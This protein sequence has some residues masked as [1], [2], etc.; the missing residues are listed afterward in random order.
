MGEEGGGGC[1]IW[2]RKGETTI[3]SLFCILYYN[4]CDEWYL[5]GKK[6]GLK[7]EVFK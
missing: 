6:S 7:I 1:K 3:E 2:W 5:A 4:N